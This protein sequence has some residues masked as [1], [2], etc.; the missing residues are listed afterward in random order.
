M[1]VSA[2]WREQ[3][4]GRRKDS[5]ETTVVALTPVAW[6]AQWSQREEREVGRKEEEPR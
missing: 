2:Q 6:R 3:Q 5:S 1:E 4:G